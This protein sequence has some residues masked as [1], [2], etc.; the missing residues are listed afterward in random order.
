MS[1][2]FEITLSKTVSAVDLA[3]ALSELIP[4]GLRV[5]VRPEMADLPE[6]PGAIWALVFVNDDPAW[7]CVLSAQV[8]RDECDLGLYPDLRVAAH[9]WR[10]FGTDSLCST[11][12]FVGELDPQD[13]YWSLACLSGQ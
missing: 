1:E 3:G 6:E 9:L 12:P 13:P 4:P 8:C 2:S 7:P 10:R 5:D 11:Y